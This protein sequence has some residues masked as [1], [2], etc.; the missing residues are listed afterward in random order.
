MSG[1]ARRRKPHDGLVRYTF[2]RPEAVGVVL[3]RVLPASLV[4]C[5]DFD[6]MRPWPTVDSDRELHVRAADLRFEM[7]L[8]DAGR[9]VPL[10][11]M[12]EHQSTLEPRFP[13]RALAYL[14]DFWAG[15]IRDHPERTTVP[16]IV[17]VLIAQH[18]ARD[19]PRRLTEVLDLPSR[20]RGMLGR[21]VELKMYVDDLSGSVLGDRHAS[22]PVLALVEITRALLHAYRNSSTLT[23]ARLETL[24]SQFDVLLQRND[25]VGNEDVHALLRYVVTVFGNQSPVRDMIFGAMSRRV[26]EM[27][28]TIEDGLLARGR[29]EA[30][31]EVLGHRG[32][33]VPDAVRDRV[34]SMHDP[35]V[36]KQWL[37]RA[38]VVGS[39]DALF[40]D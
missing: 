12:L 39:A 33:S 5:I 40:A 14:G 4:S 7:D 30:L 24:A 1:D 19:T 29:A 21:S 8:V 37:A 22:P 9:R 13:C 23:P 31:L 17:P 26:G 27:Y 32:L 18:P 36:L 2:R 3:R 35:R 38:V 34:L 10:Y 16:A 15:Y 28:L 20:F 11:A 6:S 25:P